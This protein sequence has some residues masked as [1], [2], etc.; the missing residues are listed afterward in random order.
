MVVIPRH[1][2]VFRLEEGAQPWGSHPTLFEWGG[3]DEPQPARPRG[4]NGSGMS[5]D[6][7]LGLEAQPA[8]V[9]PSTAYKIKC[10][11]CTGALSLKEGCRVCYNCGYSAC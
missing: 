10:P 11:E 3:A 8:L 5:L 6:E 2:G 7:R 4:G 1:R 9:T